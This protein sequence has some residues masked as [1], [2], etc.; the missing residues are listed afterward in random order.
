M[1]FRVSI[2]FLIGLGVGAFLLGRPHWIGEPAIVAG[3]ICG[4]GH[5][6]EHMLRRRPRP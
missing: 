4:L 2:Y 5:V 3:G 6:V 1:R